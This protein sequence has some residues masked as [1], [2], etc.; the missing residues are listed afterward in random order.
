MHIHISDED[1]SRAAIIIAK[2]SIDATLIKQLCDRDK[3]VLELRYRSTRIFAAS[4]YLDI[5]EEIDEKT[6]KVDEILQYN[7]GS[8]FIIAM[9]SNSISTGWYDNKTNARGKTLEEYLIIRDLHIMNEESERTTFQSR[10][11]RSNIDLTIVNTYT[12]IR[13]YIHT[14]IH[15]YMHIYVHIYIHTYMHACIHT[16]VHTHTYIHA[17]ICTYIHIYIYSMN[18]KLI[19]ISSRIRNNTKTK[20][21]TIFLP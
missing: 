19:Q 15:T 7:N 16:Y 11:G 2:D 20:T 12:Y 1:K 5:T 3:V 6:A 21:C 8:G 17:Y 14:H 13:T 18:P 9:D 10:R 4:M